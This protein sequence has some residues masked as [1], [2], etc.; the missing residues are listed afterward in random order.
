MNLKAQIRVGQY[1]QVVVIPLSSIQERDGR[2][3]V[4]VW[5]PATKTFDWREIQL[6]TNDGLTAVVDSGLNGSEKIRAR[7]K[8]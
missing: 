4:Q 1:S 7:P 2:S 3:F 5:Q 8:V 6:K